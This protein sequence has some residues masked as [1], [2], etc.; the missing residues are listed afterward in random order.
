MFKIIEALGNL[1]EFIGAIAVVA[2][3]VYLS[4]QVRHSRALLEAN[5]ITMRENNRLAKAAAMDRYN[6]VVSRWRGR[7][8]ESEDVAAIWD[9]ALKG[10]PIE[11]VDAVRFEHLWVDWINTYRSNFRLANAVGDEGLKRQA[12]RSIVASMRDC[13]L[14]LKMW[15]WSRPFNE[16]S[17][18][19]FVNAIDAALAV[20]DDPTRFDVPLLEKT[21]HKPT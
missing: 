3:L 20:T 9:A 15:E 4:I 12:V 2:T 14:F 10:E 19:D 11:G 21:G 8:V 7:L 6:E 1:G 16:D 5:N 18:M 13:S 17:S